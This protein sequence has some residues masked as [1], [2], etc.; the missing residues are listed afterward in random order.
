MAVGKPGISLR[1]IGSHLARWGRAIKTMKMSDQSVGSMIWLAGLIL[2]PGLLV[3]SPAGRFF[4]IVLAGIVI[5]V[6]LFFGTGKRRLFAGILAGISL[7]LGIATYPEFI[8]DQA[9]Y[10]DH[11]RGKSFPSGKPATVVTPSHTL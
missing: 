4:C 6:P 2:V 3:D 9:A 1:G 10:R 11:V 8:K 7:L 5:V